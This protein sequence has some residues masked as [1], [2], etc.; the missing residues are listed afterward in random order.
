MV[1]G[2]FVAKSPQQAHHLVELQ[3]EEAWRACKWQLDSSQQVAMGEA[4]Q[5]TGFNVALHHTLRYEI[6]ASVSSYCIGH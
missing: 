1:K 5:Q 3:Y 6:I 4:G 2:E